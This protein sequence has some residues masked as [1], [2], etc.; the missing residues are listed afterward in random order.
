[1]LQ[2]LGGISA[3][4][5]TAVAWELGARVAKKPRLAIPF[6]ILRASGLGSRRRE[7]RTLH[8]EVWLPELVYCLGDESTHAARRYLRGLGYA[9]SPATGGA[10][11]S[12]QERPA[13]APTYRAFDLVVA[14]STL[15]L[16]GPVL[17]AIYI[18][19]R[20][21]ERGPVLIRQH[22]VGQDGE[23]FRIL[24][25]RTMSAPRFPGEGT[26]HGSRAPDEYSGQ[27]RWTSCHN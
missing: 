3:C 24:K 22:R 10:R 8:D 7:W 2:F 9:T 26:R 14:I 21:T 15:V 20:C 17:L 12:L 19:V 25:F 16:L 23:I 4:L 13:H 11:R 1:M 5:L 18:L 27:P 6:L